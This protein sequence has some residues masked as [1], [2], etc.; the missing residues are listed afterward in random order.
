MADPFG[1]MLV[2]EVRRRAA[3]DGKL[4]TARR[5]NRQVGRDQGVDIGDQATPSKAQADIF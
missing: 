2:A 1:E 5:F 4:P 3:D